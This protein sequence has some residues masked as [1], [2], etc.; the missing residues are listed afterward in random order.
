ML[1]NV[2]PTL[3]R[4]ATAPEDSPVLDPNE[5]AGWWIAGRAER[6]RP[7]DSANLDPNSLAIRAARPRSLGL[8]RTGKARSAATQKGTQL[9]SRIL[10]SEADCFQTAD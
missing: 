7:V 9:R 10:G 2:Q 8:R 5:M 1:L 6:T 3:M 4:I